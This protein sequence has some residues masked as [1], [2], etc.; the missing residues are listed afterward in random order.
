MNVVIKSVPLVCGINE[1]ASRTL[2]SRCI[3]SIL[4][5]ISAGNHFLLEFHRLSTLEYSEE[6]HSEKEQALRIYKMSVNRAHEDALAYSM[7]LFDTSFGDSFTDILR[8]TSEL[9]FKSTGYCPDSL[10]L[11]AIN[12]LQALLNQSLLIGAA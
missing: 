8:I 4:S 3:V 7:V 1:F 9:R 2:F 12:K 6:N 10:P 11:D 5:Q